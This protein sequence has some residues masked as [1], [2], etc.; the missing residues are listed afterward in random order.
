VWPQRR[1]HPARASE[2]LSGRVGCF[3]AHFPRV[4]LT[5]AGEALLPSARQTLAS[6]EETREVAA[7]L[8]GV[9]RGTLRIGLMPSFAFLDIAGPLRGFHRRHPAVELQVRPS[10]GGSLALAAELL[11]PRRA[12]V[13][14]SDLYDAASGF[15]LIRGAIKID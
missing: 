12:R 14:L 11:P 7:A 2:A 3:L 15:V 10:A 1:R 5:D 4:L 13:E 8:R 6:A 9:L